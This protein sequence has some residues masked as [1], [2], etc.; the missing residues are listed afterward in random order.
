MTKDLIF[1]NVMVVF[2]VLVCVFASGIANAEESSRKGVYLS[3]IGFFGGELSQTKKVSAGGGLRVGGGVT[4]DVAIYL[5]ATGDLIQQSDFKNILIFDA[6]LKGQYYLWNGL[7]CNAG[8]GVSIGRVQTLTILL[9]QTK[10]GFT[11]NGGVGYEFRAGE[12]FFL[13]PEVRMS[14]RRL[15]SINYFST[16]IGGQLGWHF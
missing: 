3:G 16:E 2:V 14:Y 11:A 13:A 15:A 6:L 4:E 7:Y 12:K 10:T 8:A 9:S 5:E 1:R